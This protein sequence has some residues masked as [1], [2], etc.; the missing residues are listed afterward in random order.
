MT[1]DLPPSCETG[2]GGVWWLECTEYFSLE[3]EIDLKVWCVER[4]RP[5]TWT[6]AP[7]LHSSHSTII[8]TTSQRSTL[9]TVNQTI[10]LEMVLDDCYGLYI[11][12]IYDSNLLH[13]MFRLLNLTTPVH[14]YQFS[15]LK[16]KLIHHHVG[17]W[18][19]LLSSQAR[20]MDLILFLN[21]SWLWIIFFCLYS[22]SLT[23]FQI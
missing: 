2:V 14:F 4:W 5:Q 10:K 7:I 20:V 22:T 11:L 17:L 18:P 16:S 8:N 9:L 1:S 6:S 15:S 13:S 23:S 21:A 3:T 12:D 19:L